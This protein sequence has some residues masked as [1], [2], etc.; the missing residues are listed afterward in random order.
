MSTSKSPDRLVAF[1]DAVV[2][3]AMTLLIL[4]LTEEVGTLV[5]AR[6]RPVEAITGH[7]WQIFSFVLSFAVIAR[8]WIGHHRLFAEVKEHSA[9]LI[10]VNLCWLLTI[11]VLPFPTELVGGFGGDRFTAMF[12][13][14]TILA[15][16]A[17]QTVMVLIIRRDENLARSPHSIS[18][19]WWMNAIG[20][21]VALAAALLLAG[22]VPAIGIYALLLAT[23]PPVIAHLR[24]P[25]GGAETAA[26]PQ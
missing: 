14:G 1:T 15:G 2:A 21:T 19:R 24:Y 18:D 20:T 11:V 26:D 13:I 4:P 23:L 25:R 16:S 9:P 5:A 22:L 17:C 7:R 3:I 12:Y 6:G 10:V 8:V